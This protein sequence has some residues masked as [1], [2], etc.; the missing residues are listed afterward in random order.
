MSDIVTPAAAPSGD[1]NA[2]SLPEA[3]QLMAERRAAHETAQSTDGSPPD[4]GVALTPE[5]EAVDPAATSIIVDGVALTAEEVRRGYMRQADYSRKTQGLAASAKALEAERNAKL[6]RLDDLIGALESQHTQEP[7]WA[8]MARRDPLGWVGKKVQWDNQR[9][10]VESAARVAGA[11][12]AETLAAEKRAMIADLAAADYPEW[13]DPRAAA[14]GLRELAHYA[15]AQGFTA[16]EF[17]DI[18]QARYLRTLDKARR[19]DA[20]QQAKPLI[21]K[22]LSVKPQVQRPGAKHSVPAHQ[23]GLSAAWETFLKNPTVENGAA[24]QRIKR[25]ATAARRSFDHA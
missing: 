25:E 21:A 2:L 13:Q 18:A 24:Y 16:D 5:A 4:P 9:T 6:A 17:N 14:S 7:D 10:A 11:L 15:A 22:R 8:D 23:R 3:V 1:G 12:R 19:W 20:L